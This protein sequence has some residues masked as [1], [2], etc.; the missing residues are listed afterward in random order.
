MHEK[1]VP[2]DGKVNSLSAVGRGPALGDTSARERGRA[3]LGEG[4]SGLCSAPSV[5]Q[6]PCQPSAASSSCIFK[7][8]MLELDLH[9]LTRCVQLERPLQASGQCER[10]DKA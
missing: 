7:F 6:S 8:C 10:I 3:A 5:P 9:R 4:C 2:I 1:G